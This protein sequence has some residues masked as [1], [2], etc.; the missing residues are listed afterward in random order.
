[1]RAT[2]LLFAVVG[3][4]ALCAIPASLDAGTSTASTGARSGD[5]QRIA[6]LRSKVRYVFIIYQENR[7]FD[8]YF[9]T[10]P[11]AEGLFS[12]PSRLQP[13]FSQAILNTD[14]TQSSI[15]PFRIGPR[16]Y[17]ADTDDVDH[18]HSRILA[19]MHIAAGMPLMDRF[20]LTEERKYSPTGT[21]TLLAK[22]FAELTMAHE[23]CDTVPFL[24]NYANRFVLFD[25]F[26]QLMTGPSTPGNL[27]IIGAQTGITQAL[28]HPDQTA[29]GDGDEGTGV[30]VLNDSDQFWG[31][32]SDKT[33]IGRMPV[34]PKDFPGYGT[35]INL[36][37]AT[38]PL[39]L[40][41]RSL[42][43]VVGA[44]TAP[45]TDLAD[46]RND[47]AELAR[48]GS[49]APVP[50]GW[51]EEGYGRESTDDVSGPVDA[52]GSHASY[53][54]HHNG[55]QYF[56]YV[57]NNAN[58]RAHLH[59]LGNLYDALARRTLPD[60]GVFYVKGGY[61]NVLGLKPASPDSAV[62]SNFIGDDDH[63]GY[64]D[65]Q[66][67]EANV[68]NTINAIA[69]S[70]YWAHSAI[71]LTWDDS[72][73][74]YD[75]VPPPAHTVLNGKGVISD[76]PRVPLILISPFGKT[77]AIVTAYGNHGSVVKFVDTL[78][79]IKPLASLPDER[80]ASA[81]GKARYGSAE[82]AGPDDGPQSAVT[83]LLSAFDNQRLAGRRAPISAAVAMIPDA[84]V[85]V[86][87]QNS[88]YGCHSIGVVPT[89]VRNAIPNTIPADFN[90][91]PKTNPSL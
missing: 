63:P 91:R 85:R 45:E 7:S 22:Q 9:G 75:H 43:T 66:I 81:I 35:Q 70:P 58:M 68:A 27:S 6:M 11:G 90:P 73:G 62:Q 89:D 64:S 61:R 32:P 69:R 15:S 59:G 17:A 37:Y 28:L 38:L 41:G 83:D 34:N 48:N 47:V 30:P 60:R 79:D 3:M 51:Y 25:H 56:G 72:E 80:R 84:L 54:T 42:G 67:S 10:F 50:W 18:A 14:G 53:V 88:G 8:S 36:T 2:M 86:L 19:K 57:S 20:V 39:T 46:V 74:D 31:S 12:H 26:F 78:F 77:H 40:Q 71:V 29:P 23:D 4:A 52:E 87:P 44:D 33:T 76:G 16:E 21:P 1:M 5:A 49:V 13:G 24:W 55:P 65:A 82:I